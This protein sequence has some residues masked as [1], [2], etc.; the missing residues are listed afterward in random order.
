MLQK[1][2]QLRNNGIITVK[3]GA[4]VKGEVYSQSG[5]QLKECIIKGMVVTNSLFLKT[6]SSSYVNQLLNVEIDV[7]KLD[8]NHIGLG[9]D[10]SSKIWE[11]LK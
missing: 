4:V 2:I 1:T 11:V 6:K 9:I 5:L 10:N 8:S 3:K 7:S